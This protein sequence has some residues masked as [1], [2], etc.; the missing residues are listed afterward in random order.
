MANITVL[1][2]DF[3]QGDGEYRDGNFTLR[4]SLHPWPGLTLPLSSIKTLEVAN[5]ES[6]N[7]FKDVIGYGVAGAMLLG[8]I[9]AIAG[10]M[11][12]GH[13]TE[14]T[15]LATLKDQRRMLIAADSHTFQEISRKV[16]C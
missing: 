4:T 8:P 5:E 6:I 10:F 14:V 3:L 9:G 7:N 2:G 16:A 15:F 11:L 12:A 13:E 1:A